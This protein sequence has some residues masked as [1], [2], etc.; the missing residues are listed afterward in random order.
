M[1]NTVLACNL[2]VLI[3]K[4][5]L[6]KKLGDKVYRETLFQAFKY[7]NCLQTNAFM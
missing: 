4:D 3:V 7:L 5:K 6:W 1:I 2:Y